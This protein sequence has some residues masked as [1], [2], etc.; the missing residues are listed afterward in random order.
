MD[1]EGGVAEVKI[2]R[3]T[4]N[5]GSHHIIVFDGTTSDLLTSSPRPIKICIRHL[6]RPSGF[7]WRGAGAGSTWC[8]GKD[9]NF[10]VRRCPIHNTTIPVK[11]LT[12]PGNG[13]TALCD[14]RE[15]SRMRARFISSS[16]L[17]PCSLPFP[18]PPSSASTSE[19]ALSIPITMLCQFPSRL[20]PLLSSPSLLPSQ[21]SNG[22]RKGA[23][24]L[25]KLC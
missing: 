22:I 21:N 23:G 17:S 4:T 20:P 2:M 18:C 13:K 8:P 6:S 9:R 11:T 16:S 24:G 10:T 5:A 3:L 1:H 15:N 25:H 12:P 14:Q 19:H 7:S